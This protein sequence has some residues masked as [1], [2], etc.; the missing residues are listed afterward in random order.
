MAKDGGSQIFTQKITGGTPAAVT[1]GRVP[2][3]DEYSGFIDAGR[4]S[5][6]TVAIGMGGEGG[7]APQGVWLMKGTKATTRLD[8]D[9]LNPGGALVYP[10]AVIG[11]K[12]VYFPSPFS[13]DEPTRAIVEFDVKTKKY[14]SIV[15]HGSSY[16]GVIQG[17]AVIDPRQ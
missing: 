2:G 15:G 16:D 12:V 6:G 13:E 5:V 4:T 1:S 17:S 7:D 3:L 11:D 10:S 14:V 9:K 8:S